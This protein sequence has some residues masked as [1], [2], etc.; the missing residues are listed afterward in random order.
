MPLSF[1]CGYAYHCPT[2]CD[3]IQ[4]WMSKCKDDSE[5]AHYIS[6]NT[7]PVSATPGTAR[8]GGG[9]VTVLHSSPAP[10]VPRVLRQH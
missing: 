2:T 10:A 9:C 3:V 5:T 7:K 8:C 6:A 1:K 4:T